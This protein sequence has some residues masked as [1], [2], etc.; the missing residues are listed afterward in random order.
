MLE[1]EGR[2]E[3]LTAPKGPAVAPP[4]LTDCIVMMGPLEESSDGLWPRGMGIGIVEA[5]ALL[6]LNPAEEKAPAVVR[7]DECGLEKLVKALWLGRDHD[8]PRP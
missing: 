2:S 3:A 6:L 5:P 4:P 1:D 7:G 8:V